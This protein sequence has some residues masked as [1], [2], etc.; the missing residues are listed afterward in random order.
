MFV[1][2]P[3]ISRRLLSVQLVVRPRLYRV[4][5]KTEPFLKCIILLYNEIGRQSIYQNVQ[6]F[7]RSKDD[8][9]NAAIVIYSLHKVRET[10][11]H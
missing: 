5:Q 11:L 9:L 6:L 7:I 8:I 1:P 3:A 2:S 4:G 10:I